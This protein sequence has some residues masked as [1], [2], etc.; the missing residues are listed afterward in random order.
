VILN[1]DQTLAM[2]YAIGLDMTT[3][4]GYQLVAKVPS[5]KTTFYVWEYLG[6]V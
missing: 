5:G 1:Y 2:D 4:G 6:R 3:S